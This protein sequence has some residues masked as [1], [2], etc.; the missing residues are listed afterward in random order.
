MCIKWFTHCLFSNKMFSREINL[1]N[2]RAADWGTQ[3]NAAC[4]QLLE[5]LRPIAF[6]ETCHFLTIQSLEFQE[7]WPENSLEAMWMI[8]HE[9]SEFWHR[10]FLI[11]KKTT[12]S[13][14]WKLRMSK[15]YEN[16]V[17]RRDFMSIC[18]GQMIKKI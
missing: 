11:L 4:V 18:S 17:D 5:I 13:E 2:P 12:Y 1:R 7:I 3:L 9:K 6:T 10:E 14:L 16:S 15:F 8:C